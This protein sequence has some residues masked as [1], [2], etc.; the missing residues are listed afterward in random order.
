MTSPVSET[1]S[2]WTL[3]SHN[4]SVSRICGLCYDCMIKLK[5]QTS[6]N[7]VHLFISTITK[8]QIDLI[9]QTP[10]LPKDY[11]L[12]CSILTNLY[13]FIPLS[14]KI[15]Q[16]IVQT[17]EKNWLNIFLHYKIRKH[18]SNIKWII[19]FFFSFLNHN[20]KNK[21]KYS[22]QSD[23]CGYSSDESFVFEGEINV[24]P[25]EWCVCNTQGSNPNTCYSKLFFNTC[26]S[27]IFVDRPSVDVI[28]SHT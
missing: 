17:F 25:S 12:L 5:H 26:Q 6:N 13:M 15:K 1:F 27:N 2:N 14:K 18:N 19:P 10:S 7:Y 8:N 28:V 20:M 9:I 21:Q 24:R 23:F 11:T 4:N 16:L 3:N 22:R